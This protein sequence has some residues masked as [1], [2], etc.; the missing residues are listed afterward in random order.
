MILLIEG[1][2][3]TVLGEDQTHKEVARDFTFNDDIVKDCVG[4]FTA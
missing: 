2:D 4:A 3:S 1:F